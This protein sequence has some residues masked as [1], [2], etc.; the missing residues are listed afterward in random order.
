VLCVLGCVCCLGCFLGFC[1]GGLGRILCVSMLTLGCL[2]KFVCCLGLLGLPSSQVGLMLV[3]LLLNVKYQFGFI[4]FELL[5]T[6]LAFQLSTSPGFLCFGLQFGFRLFFEFIAWEVRLRLRFFYCAWY[7]LVLLTLGIPT[8]Q[9]RL[10][11]VFEAEPTQLCSILAYGLWKKVIALLV[12]KPS[13]N[14][15]RL[16]G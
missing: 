4:F 3:R 2:G 14:T 16:D 10:T 13:L 1:L 7:C 9:L 12:I 5:V 6:E 8:S 11:P 15:E